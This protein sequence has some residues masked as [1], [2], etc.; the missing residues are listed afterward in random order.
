MSLTRS[1]AYRKKSSDMPAGAIADAPAHFSWI[2]GR[3]IRALRK[4]A[5]MTQAALGRLLGITNQAVCQFEG[6]LRG[7]PPEHY[8]A[9]ADLFDLD[10]KS[11]AEFLIRHTSPWAYAMLHPE[12]KEVLRDIKNIR[13]RSKLNAPD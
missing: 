11:W 6:G 3:E 5:G 13:R 2:I 12:D 8:K 4:E 7:L 1:L 10:E 9:I